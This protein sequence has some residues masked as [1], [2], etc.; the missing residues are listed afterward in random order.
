M[1]E[2]PQDLN[3]TCSNCRYLTRSSV[4]ATRNQRV[5]SA[6]NGDT[7]IENHFSQVAST[8]HRAIDLHKFQRK[9]REDVNYL[10]TRFHLPVALNQENER[11]V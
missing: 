10:I 8:L 2:A 4:P 11:G 6:F 3:P 7:Q 5:L 9:E 1:L